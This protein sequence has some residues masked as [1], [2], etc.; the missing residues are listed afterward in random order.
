MIEANALV[1]RTPWSRMSRRLASLFKKSSNDVR[2]IKN[3]VS[4]DSLGSL[5]SQSS[6]SMGDSHASSPRELGE[7]VNWSQRLSLSIRRVLG[8]LA[9]DSTLKTE[10]RP[11]KTIN[12]SSPNVTGRQGRQSDAERDSLASFSQS[13]SSDAL[14]GTQG[15]ESWVPAACE[16]PDMALKWGG[17]NGTPDGTPRANNA[18]QAASSPRWGSPTRVFPTGPGEVVEN[19]TARSRDDGKLKYEKLEYK[20]DS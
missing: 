16:D 6:D 2:S 13:R 8:P 11:T 18:P 15:R 7:T 3:S 9:L 10:R 20:S 14:S 17:E 5:F 4:S 1:S 19:T 12:G